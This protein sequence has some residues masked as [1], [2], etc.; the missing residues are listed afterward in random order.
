MSKPKHSLAVM[1]ACSRCLSGVI[2]AMAAEDA[3]KQN[4]GW[5]QTELCAVELGADAEQIVNRSVRARLITIEPGGHNMQ[6]GHSYRPTIIYILEGELTSYRGEQP[7]YVLRAGE[8]S[9]Q[10]RELTHHWLQNTGT[11][12]AKYLSIDVPLKDFDAATAPWASR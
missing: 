9:V 8:C 10:P 12:L 6:H 5:K 4:K 3:P 1:A 2:P 11:G 7:G